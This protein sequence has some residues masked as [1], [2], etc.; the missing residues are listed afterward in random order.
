MRTVSGVC[1]SRRIQLG[2]V[3]DGPEFDEEIGNDLERSRLKGSSR[4]VRQQSRQDGIRRHCDS[5]VVCRRARC[6][7]WRDEPSLEDGEALEALFS[8]ERRFP[9]GPDLFDKDAL[10]EAELAFDE[11]CRVD[12]RVVGSSL[13]AKQERGREVGNEIEGDEGRYEEFE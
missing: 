2:H 7:K 5:A 8:P 9:I 13:K 4:L 11:L 6:T 10:H 1:Q 3:E 12:R